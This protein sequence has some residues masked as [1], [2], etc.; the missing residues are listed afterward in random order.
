MIEIKFGI[1][2]LDILESIKK[3]NNLEDIKK[4]REKILDTRNANDVIELVNQLVNA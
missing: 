4:I 3:I 2:C 1:S